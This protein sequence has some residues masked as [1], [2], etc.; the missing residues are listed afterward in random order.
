MGFADHATVFVEAGRGGDGRLSFQHTL[1]NPGRGGPDGG[2]GSGGG[3]VFLVADATLNTL[4][5]Y[6]YRRLW[7]A[8]AGGSGGKG[9]RTGK[10]GADL[11]LKV[12][13]GT[14][15]R[16][17]ESGELLG[18]LCTPGAT[19]LV[20]RG[21]A[22]GLGNTHFKSS[23]QRTPRRTTRGS[24]GENRHLELRLR[25]LADVGLVGAPNSGRSSLLRAL[26]SA[27]PEIADYP[28]TTRIP[29][30]GVVQLEDYRRFTLVDI[31]SM[32]PAHP[33]HSSPPAP[34]ASPSPPSSPQVGASEG[35]FLHHLERTRLLLWVVEVAADGAVHKTAAAAGA[36]LEH[37]RRCQPFLEEI[38]SWL[39]LNKIDRIPTE[40][41]RNFCD[42]AARLLA[43]QSPIYGVSALQV[44]LESLRDNIMDHLD[45]AYS[46][47]GHGVPSV[48]PQARAAF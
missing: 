22:H 44:G 29:T 13:L 19:L 31:P 7:R 26:S 27:Q 11:L 28:Y 21:G 41:R 40:Q 8:A 42:E 6:R 15:V 12:P 37:C 46:R 9:N 30:L 39:L 18:D 32:H 4:V 24:S 34:P 25:I 33:P 38:P 17:L 16:D 20:A 10:K 47:G 48:Q 36:L 3:D 23:I 14:R 45:R 43:W 1:K 35:G 5:D 2:N